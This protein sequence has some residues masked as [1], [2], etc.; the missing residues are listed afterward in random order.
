MTSMKNAPH[1]LFNGQALIATIE[2][3]APGGE[4][5]TRELGVPVF[6][7]RVAPGDKVE[8][9]L[10]DVRKNFARARLVRI[11]EPSTRRAE[12]PCKLFKVCGGCQW[13]HLSYEWQAKAK[14]EIVRQTVKH[15]GGLNPDL[16]QACIGANQQFFYRNKVQFPVENPR[17]STRILAGYYKQDSHELVNIKHCPVQPEPLDRLLVS[18]KEV[19]ERH[20]IPAY[21]EARRTGLVRHVAARYSFSRRQIL[22]TLVVNACDPAAGG[23][24]RKSEKVDIAMWREISREIREAVP[25]IEGVCLNFNPHAGNRILGESTVVLAG[26]GQIIE[27]LATKRA[28]LPEK[29][30]KGLKFRLSSTSFFQIHTDQ[31]VRL[32]E[33]IVD[34]ASRKGGARVPL[35]IDAYAGVGA[36]ALWLSP[37]AERV[38]AVEESQAAV[39]DGNFNLELN[40]AANVEFICGTVESVFPQLLESGMRADV[41]VL[42]PPRKGLSP[43]A[44]DVALALSPGRIVYVSCNP[45]TLAR[46]LKIIERNGYKTKQ[47]QPID[48]F[49]QTYHIESVTILDRLVEGYEMIEP[50]GARS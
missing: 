42:D 5:V 13:Q 17:G 14:E 9:E 21:D 39:D 10:F 33:L 3:L 34:A 23:E 15:I 28:D 11:I 35:V 30:Q 12:P 4:G 20:A 47:I 49:P 19:L 38:V 46:D 50:A 31:A 1:R 18:V 37:I 29:L 48:L 36:I 27:E 6:V 22:L 43:A 32:M 16:V 8:L 24:P 45:A 7:N 26:E 2:S 41:V 40:Q 25:E 44:L